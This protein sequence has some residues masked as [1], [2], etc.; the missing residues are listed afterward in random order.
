M[1]CEMFSAE[2]GHLQVELD[3]KGSI[4]SLVTVSNDR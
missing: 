3:D 4:E 2:S 1:I